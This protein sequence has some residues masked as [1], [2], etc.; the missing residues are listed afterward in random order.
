LACK[1]PIRGYH[2]RVGK[3]FPVPK[4]E[5]KASPTASSSSCRVAMV[6][7]KSDVA[8][9]TMHHVLQTPL[10]SV[11]ERALSHQFYGKF[12]LSYT[13][14][15]PSSSVQRRRVTGRRSFCCTLLNITPLAANFTHISQRSKALDPLMT[16]ETHAASDEAVTCSADLPRIYW[17]FGNAVNH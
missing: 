7:P 1:G 4:R 11:P 16:P 5:A 13:N 14:V 12:Q 9:V 17:D 8:T 6:D 3:G 15:R 10:A 2:W